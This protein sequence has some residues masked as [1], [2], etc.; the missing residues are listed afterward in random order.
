MVAAIAMPARSQLCSSDAQSAAHVTPSLS[1]ARLHTVQA[2]SDH[3]VLLEGTLLKPNMVRPAPVSHPPAT[4][5]LCLGLHHAFSCIP[6][7]PRLT[8]SRCHTRDLSCS[9]SSA[10]IVLIT[11]ISYAGDTRRGWQAGIAAGNRRGDFQVAAAHCAAR[12]AR[13]TIIRRGPET[14]KP[15]GAALHVER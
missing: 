4:C 9:Y 12:S 3:H 11:F 14:L 7:P 5:C 1:T 15:A 13:C 8:R 6:S 2:L 10:V